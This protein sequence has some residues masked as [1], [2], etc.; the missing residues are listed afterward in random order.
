MQE[1]DGLPSGYSIHFLHTLFLPLHEPLSDLSDT[2][3]DDLVPRVLSPIR[4]QKS[5][6]RNSS[7]FVS[8][9]CKN[10]AAALQTAYAGENLGFLAYPISLTRSGY[11]RILPAFHRKVIYWK[12]DRSDLFV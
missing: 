3:D 6:F 10:C 4:F 1:L 2:R 5:F 7:L 12:D 11:P 8:L 9:Y